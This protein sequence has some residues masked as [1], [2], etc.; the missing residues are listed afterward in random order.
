MNPHYFASLGVVVSSVF[1]YHVVIRYTPAHVH[2]IL[3]LAATYVVAFL[4]T[5]ALFFAFPLKGALGGELRA[6]PWAS[7]V[8]GIT[9]VGIEAGFLWAYRSGWTLGT[10]ALTANAAAAVLLLLV[11]LLVFKDDLGLKQVAGFFV[12][13]VGLWLL[14]SKSGH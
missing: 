3:S 14:N 7:Y 11:G 5:L 13:L 4:A 12:C 1:L 9:I 2:P 6:L 10:A 8:L